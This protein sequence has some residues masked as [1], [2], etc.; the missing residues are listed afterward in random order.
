MHFK[1]DPLELVGTVV[2][3][4]MYLVHVQITRTL[5]G[6]VRHEVDPSLAISASRLVRSD[7]RRA[8]VPV[9]VYVADQ[10]FISAGTI[11]Q[12]LRRSA[13][14]EHWAEDG[15]FKRCSRRDIDWTRELLV[16]NEA[17]RITDLKLHVKELI[18][19]RMVRLRELC[20]AKRK[21]A[22]KENGYAEEGVETLDVKPSSE[23][24][25]CSLANQLFVKEH[26]LAAAD[27]LRQSFD[28][29]QH[30]GI[31]RPSILLKMGRGTTA[32]GRKRSRVV[33]QEKMPKGVKG[34][35]RMILPAVST[36]TQTQAI[37]LLKYSPVEPADPEPLHETLLTAPTGT[38]EQDNE[39]R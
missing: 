35:P 37:A 25:M 24:R 19:K 18:R 23:A 4:P 10:S 26:E 2:D 9:A 20:E 17:C 15:F 14:E 21:M 3:E 6:Q 5:Q 29:S 36:P 32:P 34:P 16:S 8:V 33:H 13:I 38:V 1:F 27:T 7:G 28:L 12:C 39:A 31:N 11:R 22:S 30:K